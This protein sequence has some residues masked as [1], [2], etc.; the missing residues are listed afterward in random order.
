MLQPERKPK[1]IHTTIIVIDIKLRF[2]IMANTMYYILYKLTIDWN[3]PAMNIM[4]IRIIC[5]VY[6]EPFRS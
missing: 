5:R 1:P 3:M 4:L 2:L 6:R